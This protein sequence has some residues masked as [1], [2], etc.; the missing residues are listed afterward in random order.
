MS[1]RFANEF[2]EH[3]EE[4]LLLVGELLVE[5]LR[6]DARELRDLRVGE[7]RVA[8]VERQVHDRAEH[9]RALVV[10]RE[11]RRGHGR[12]VPAEASGAGTPSR[13]AAGMR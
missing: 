11:E 6:G 4:A 12:L 13:A 1:S 7:P 3:G 8:F 5:G 10:A 2:V 9:P